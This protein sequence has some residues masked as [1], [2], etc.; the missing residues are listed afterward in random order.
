MGMALWKAEEGDPRPEGMTLSLINP[1][2]PSCYWGYHKVRSRPSRLSL[3][4]DDY[5]WESRSDNGARTAAQIILMAQARIL[6]VV[7]GEVVYR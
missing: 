2:S 1:I 6:D 3:C 5:I 4:P 7:D